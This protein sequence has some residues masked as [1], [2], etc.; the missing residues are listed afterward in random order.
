LLHTIVERDLFVG[1]RARPDI[2]TAVT[3]LCTRV[4]GPD[5]D[6]SKKIR[7]MIYYMK[8]KGDDVLALSANTMHVVKWWVDVSYATHADY[9][10]QTGDPC[11]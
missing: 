2:L 3:F 10:I 5:E 7:Q 1:K 11:L 4:K 9:R 8:R 6:D